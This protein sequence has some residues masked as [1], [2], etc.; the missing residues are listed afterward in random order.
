MSTTSRILDYKKYFITI[1]MLNNIHALT[2][3]ILL[4]D[5]RVRTKDF[6]NFLKCIMDDWKN[7]KYIIQRKNLTKWITLQL[8]KL[9]V[10]KQEVNNMIKQRAI[11]LV[12]Q[13]KVQ[14]QA[15]DLDQQANTLGVFWTSDSTVHIWD[16]PN[17]DNLN[18]KWH[19]SQNRI[20]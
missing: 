16:I 14:V 20:T 11:C 3:Q 12:Q 17:I 5:F 6:H 9:Q 2:L 1:H 8:H 15:K 7:Y 19:K 18:H 10:H 13:V 4:N